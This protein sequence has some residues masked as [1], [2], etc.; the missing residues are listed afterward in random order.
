MIRQYLLDVLGIIEYLLGYG[1]LPVRFITGC[2]VYQCLVQ[3]PNNGQGSDEKQE[4]GK[5]HNKPDVGNDLPLTMEIPPEIHSTPQH[6][7]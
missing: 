6:Q 2:H 3:L 1:T 5:R 4:E 7:A